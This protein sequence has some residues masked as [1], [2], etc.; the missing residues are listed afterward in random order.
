MRVYVLT[1]VLKMIRLLV[2]RIDW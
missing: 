1:A 2:R